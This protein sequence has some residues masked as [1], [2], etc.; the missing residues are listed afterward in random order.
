MSNP[1]IYDNVD[2]SPKFD[3]IIKQRGLRIIH[4]N[5]RSLTHKIDELRNMAN[6]FKSE[7][8]IIALTETWANEQILDG[9]FEIPVYNIFRK[10]R[11]AKGGGVLVFVRSDLS[12]FRRSDLD[13]TSVEGLW[14]EF[15][16]PNSR[17]VLVGTFYRPPN[18]SRFYDKDF[19]S[20]FDDILDIVGIQGQEIIV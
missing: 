20:K 5:I 3:E 1:S 6:E 10:D 16:I 9:E 2:L 19:M 14:L 7:I 4:Q 17:G 18:S 8:H 13:D 11:D 12:V 15:L